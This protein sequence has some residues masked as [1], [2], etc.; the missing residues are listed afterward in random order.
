MLVSGLRLLSWLL[1]VCCWGRLF[2]G[3]LL[4]VAGVVSFLVACFWAAS[5]LLVAC[6]LL[7][8]SSLS[9][10]LVV[11]FWAA[12]SFLVALLFVAGFVSISSPFVSRWFAIFGLRAGS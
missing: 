5:S 4:F 11:C 9:W 2:L 8:G 3:C 10:L 6:C 12:S 1:V 7:L